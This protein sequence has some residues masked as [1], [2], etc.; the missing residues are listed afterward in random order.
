MAAGVDHLPLRSGPLILTWP[1]LFELCN[2]TV[3]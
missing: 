1:N 2:D 3:P